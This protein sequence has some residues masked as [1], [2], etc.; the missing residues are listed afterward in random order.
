MTQRPAD[1]AIFRKARRENRHAIAREPDIRVSLQRDRPLC[2]HR[3][4]R[5]AHAAFPDVPANHLAIGIHAFASVGR[6][7]VARPDSQSDTRWRRR[8]RFSS[9]SRGALRRIA[10][11]RHTA[12]ESRASLADSPYLAQFFRWHS[13]LIISSAPTP[14]PSR[15]PKLTATASAKRGSRRPRL[16]LRPSGWQDRPRPV[17]SGGS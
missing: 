15:P 8:T 3:R 11:L 1:S 6:E 13:L 10:W 2:V 14:S 4:S 7:F 9:D 12:F 16:R 5:G 17:R